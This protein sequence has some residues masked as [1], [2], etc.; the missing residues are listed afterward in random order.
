MSAKHSNCTY[1]SVNNS[2][3]LFLEGWLR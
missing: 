2:Y 3:F 1:Y